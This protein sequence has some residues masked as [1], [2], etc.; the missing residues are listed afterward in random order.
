MSK[1]PVAIVLGG[2]NPHIALIKNLQKRGYH[3][4]LID[5]FEN[6][7]AA[8]FADEHIRESTLDQE[9]VLEISKEIDAKLVISACIDQANVTA[10]YVAEQLGLPKPYS[11]A[12]SLNVTDKGIMKE[13]MLEGRIPTS[14]YI[15]VGQV[16][17]QRIS[18]L[19]FPLVVKPSDCTGSKGVRKATTHHELREY[20]TS[21]LQVGRAH[22]AIVEE[23]KEGMEVQADFFVKDGE[24]FFVMMRQKIKVVG[25]KG[26]IL[27]SFGSI[28]PVEVSEKAR[29][30]M[31]KVANQI[32][33]TFKLENTSLFFQA[34]VN[35]DEVNIVEFAAR[36]GGGLSYRMIQ[37]MAGF[38]IL[39]AT[40][41]SYF[42]IPVEVKY[43]HPESCY[44]TVIIYS[45]P[46]IFDSVSGYQE[47]LEQKGIE[48]FFFFKTRGM[49]VGEELT[50]GNRVGAFLTKADNPQ[51][52]L[53]KMNTA[54]NKL[55]ILDA[56][57][58]PIMRKDIYDGFQL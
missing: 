7:P 16:D 55:E 9:K 29:A 36:V 1:H 32:V 48:E 43:K 34:I 40:V 35:G 5:Y 33:Q 54:V 15:V 53:K 8:E 30:N 25:G 17:D 14:K 49:Q 23:F 3:V 13:M 18:S 12:T 2:T 39:D 28:I 6:P 42:G 51:E 22:K 45:R 31:L 21:A 41:D 26:T 52:L 58:N 44:S 57:G 19:K 20:L 50:S 11:H 4:V 27:Q 56:E 37:V 24:A 47:L 10:C 46:G 38:D